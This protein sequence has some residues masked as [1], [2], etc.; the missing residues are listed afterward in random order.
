MSRPLTRPLILVL[1]LV[2]PVAH[3]ELPGE[4][5]DRDL[6][7]LQSL[8]LTALGPVPK[9]PSNRVANDA[10]VAE[11]GRTLFF[12]TD[13]S[14]DGSLSCASCHQE[15]RAFTDGKP[16]A[17]GVH[18]TARNT[19]TLYGAAYLDWFYWDGRRDSLW[20]Q[21]LIPIEASSEMAASRVA[22]VRLISLSPDYRESYQALFGSLP[23]LDWDNLPEHATPIG[24]MSRQNAWYRLPRQT[25]QKINTVF[26]NLGKALEAFQRTLEL[27]ETRFDR[28]VVALN[29]EN[30]E[31][32]DEL[33]SEEE[34][35]GIKLYTDD[36][37]TQCLRCHSGP[38]LSN[39]GFHNIG[40]GRFSGEAMD[41]GR[42]FGLQA[43]LMDEFNCLGDYSDA[44]ADQCH[45]LN[46]VSQDAHQV[47]HGAFKTPTLRNLKK[48]S[49]YFHDGRF[50]SLEEVIDY[51]QAPPSIGPNKAHELQP[52]NLTDEEKK[53]LIAFLE[54]LN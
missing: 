31:R 17:E 21:A 6:R 22:A 27:P 25:Q 54:M 50:S 18:R 32:A 7:I 45:A 46:H 37:R 2:A 48:T 35:E 9:E 10:R 33:I 28:F 40:T 5:T 43:V 24:D 23:K 47:L 14:I 39:G 38:L 42:V 44:K 15:E 8:S 51:Y 11:L 1:F 16:L 20:S 12:D 13:L 41:F 29:Q 4:L 36:Q 30:W 52:L 26:A 3:A 19:P 53:A 34:L 49:P